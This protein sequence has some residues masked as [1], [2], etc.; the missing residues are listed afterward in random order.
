MKRHKQDQL[1]NELLAGE[2]VSD[3]RRLSLARTL[4]AI[5]RRN[6]RGRALRAGGLAALPVLL[7]TALVLVRLQHS[8]G[9][10]SVR[11][12]APTDVAPASTQSAS[13]KAITDEEL[14]A[15]YPN[16]PMALIGPPGHQ[17]LVFLDQPAPKG[18]P[19]PL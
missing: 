15:L 9:P 10:E 19:R 2:E 13:V 1:L 11:P 6:R 18:S 16:R 8:A 7:A 17:R 12:L 4:E 5:Q 3:F 14:F